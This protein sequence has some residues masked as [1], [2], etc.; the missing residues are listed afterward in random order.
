MREKS[1]KSQ[2]ILRWMISGNP[3]IASLES[4]PIYLKL[5]YNMDYA[6]FV[7]HCFS[8][9][10]AQDHR[11]KVLLAQEEET[12]QVSKTAQH[13]NQILG[14]PATVMNL[15]MCQLNVCIF[16]KFSPKEKCVMLALYPK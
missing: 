11:C 7:L 4:I 14:Q 8:H 1:G 10:H 15:N 16:F 12:S 5:C 13:V 2:G 6:M 9:R 3:G